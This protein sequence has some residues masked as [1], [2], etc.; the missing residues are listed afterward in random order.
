MGAS[1]DGAVD[2]DLAARVL[3]GAAVGAHGVRR[4]A[5][6]TAVGPLDRHDGLRTGRRGAPVMMRAASPGPTVWSPESPSLPAATSPMTVSTAGNSSLAPS[7]S[8][9][10]TA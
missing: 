10:R 3:R 2:A 6:R 9:V 7:R 8:A 1:R 4:A 5:A